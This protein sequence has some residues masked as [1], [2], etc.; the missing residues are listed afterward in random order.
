MAYRGIETAIGGSGN[1]VFDSARGYW[2]VSLC[3]E[4]DRFEK[5]FL[6]LIVHKNRLD[7]VCH[8]HLDPQV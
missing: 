2:D 7:N 8:M 4:V 1:R 5:Q 3:I 6:V